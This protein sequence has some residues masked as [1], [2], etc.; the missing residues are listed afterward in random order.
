M[1]VSSVLKGSAVYLTFIALSWGKSNFFHFLP[2]FQIIVRILKTSD[3]FYVFT[4]CMVVVE[5]IL[6]FRYGITI[7]FYYFFPYFIFDVIKSVEAFI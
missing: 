7:M 4:S 2:I 6:H 1:H 5:S 3:Q